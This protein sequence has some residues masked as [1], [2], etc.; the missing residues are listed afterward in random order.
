MR[1]I[2]VLIVSAVTAAGVLF[3][4]PRLQPSPQPVVIRSQ[5]PTI[6]RLEQLSH[7]VTSRVY[8]ADVL[9]GDGEGCKGAWLIKGDALIA[10]NLGRAK[11]TAK[12]NEARTATLVLPLPEALQPRVD[13]ERS[14][15]WEVRRMVWLPWN[16]DPDKLRDA[17]M[18]QAQ[19]LVAQAA[20]S[21][22]NL[23]QAKTGVSTILKA[24]YAEVGW[25]VEVIWE[26]PDTKSVQT[27]C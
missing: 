9:I 21:N 2:I 14:P 25:Q 23:Q 15:T 7:L 10:V 11:I 16:A 24:F 5:G 27:S 18:E 20:G 1:A 17:V 19:R 12:D 4:L 22:E 6:E 26:V 13:H 8:V 3:A